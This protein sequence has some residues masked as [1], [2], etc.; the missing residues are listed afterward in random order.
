MRRHRIQRLLATVLLAAILAGSMPTATAAATGFR[1][2]PTAHWAASS[3]RRAVDLGIFKGETATTFGVGH[4]I[5]RGAFVVALGRFFGWDTTVKAG[6]RGVYSDVKD[7]AAWYYGAVN[8]AFANGTLTLQSDTFRPGDP[9]TREELAVML[10][11]ALGYGT[12]AGLPTGLGM[13]FKDVRT[14]A[15][16]ISMAYHLGLF[17]G[18]GKTTFSPDAT[19]P[20][21]QAAVIL[22][23]LYD[24][25]HQPA[26]QRVGILPA[27]TETPDLTG[28]GAVAAAGGRMVY[29]GGALLNNMPEPAAVTALQ[30]AAKSAG[31]P[32]LL[33]ISAS[34]LALRG[35]AGELSKLLS[36]AVASGGWDG[37]FLDM[38][39]LK[40]DSRQAMTALVKALDGALGSRMLYVAAE[41]PAFQGASYDGYDYAALG[42]AADRLVL[43]VAPYSFTAANGFP[44]N[45]QEPLEGV[46]VALARLRGAVPGEKLSV[47]LTTTAN[48]WT[49]GRRT[50]ILT[51][52]EVSALLGQKGTEVHYADRYACAY[53]TRAAAGRETVVWYLD[54]A[55]AA[56]RARML[57]FFGV[58]QVC[59]SDVRSVS[60]DVLAG[61]GK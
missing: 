51:A 13:P 32:A 7:P 50:G 40:Y 34:S 44:T 9:I 33:H 6:S 5:T 15:G 49:D 45:P 60:A 27:G 24:K 11:R 22:V 8:A 39:K 54:R 2:V 57:A 59:L 19:A 53:L 26:P 52:A 58:S 1:D 29:S 17:G 16:Y 12:I 41:A 42:A 23:R 35:T 30:G 4:S 55:G 31:I 21:E 36:D 56:E 3:I 38:P 20:R 28:Y 14:N 46:Y 25:L 47:M 37:L 43:R 18:T 48:G 61:L 10:V